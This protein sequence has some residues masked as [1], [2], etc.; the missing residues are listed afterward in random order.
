[1]I[2]FAAVILIAFGWWC[3]RA[4]RKQPVRPAPTV[5]VVPVEIVVQLPQPK[6]TADDFAQ[7]SDELTL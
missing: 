6:P 2:L 7:W 1:M 3:I 4:S 5:V